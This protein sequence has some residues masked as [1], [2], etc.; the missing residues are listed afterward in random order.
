MSGGVLIL[1]DWSLS[2]PGLLECLCFSELLC[3]LPPESPYVSPHLYQP[4]SGI[5]SSPSLRNPRQA[6]DGGPQKQ[7]PPPLWWTRSL[8]MW[9]CSYRRWER[10][11]CAAR[12]LWLLRFN[13]S[14]R[15]CPVCVVLTSVCLTQRSRWSMCPTLVLWLTHKRWFCAERTASLKV[16][17]KYEPLF[18]R[19]GELTCSQSSWL[20]QLMPQKYEDLFSLSPAWSQSKCSFFFCTALIKF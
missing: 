20:T 18:V 10:A 2:F 1:P 3:F 4:G 6:D 9:V 5:L 12:N 11:E 13:E 8:W 16:E 14:V 17:K 19:T 15:S 7:K